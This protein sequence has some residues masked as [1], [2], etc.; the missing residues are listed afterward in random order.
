M[1][2][3]R[4]TP[5]LQFICYPKCSTCAKARKWLDENGIAYAE[6]DISKDRPSEEELTAWQGINGLPWKRFFNTSGMKYRALQLKDRLPGMEEKD[7]I[8]LLSS[9]GMLVKRPV[10]VGDGF[11]LLGFKEAEWEERL[12]K[13]E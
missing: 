9:D 12:G 11:V 10:L 5:V 13:G 4:K 2:K 1:D 3:E 7:V 8:S 6:R